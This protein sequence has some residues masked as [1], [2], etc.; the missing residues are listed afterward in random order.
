MR[1]KSFLHG[2][3]DAEGSAGRIVYFFQGAIGKKLQTWMYVTN[4]FAPI[5]KERYEGHPPEFCCLQRQQAFSAMCN[6]HYCIGPGHTL[7]EGVGYRNVV[8]RKPPDVS[9]ETSIFQFANY[10]V[11]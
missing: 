3:A 8:V 7:K 4:N 9:A 11:Y 6:S 5:M 10:W 2:F 1:A